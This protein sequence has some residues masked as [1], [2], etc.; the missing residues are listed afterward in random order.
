MLQGLAGGVVDAEDEDTAG[1]QGIMKER[2]QFLHHIRAR[3]E[4]KAPDVQDVQVEE[5]RMGQYVMLGKYGLFADLLADLVGVVLPGKEA[6][7]LLGGYIHL[8]VCDV[9]PP[10]RLEDA[11]PVDVGRKDLVLDIAARGLDRLFE[12]NGHAVGLLPGGAPRD[13][14]AERAVTGFCPD[15]LAEQPLTEDLPYSGVAEEPVRAGGDLLREEIDLSWVFLDVAHVVFAVGDPVQ[16]HPPLDPAADQALLEY[17]VVFARLWADQ[18]E[19]LRARIQVPLLFQARR[20]KAPVGLDI[21]GKQFRELARRRYVVGKPGDDD[22]PGHA[23]ELCGD[24]VLDHHRP[25][26]LF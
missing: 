10:P 23:R 24:R 26:A 21:I 13:P 3:V 5:R 22:A 12:R 18:G 15:Q 19:D 1:I 14:D 7:Q 16:T 25:E 8:D 20:A 17:G 11:L 9:D 2:Y 4:E 6:I